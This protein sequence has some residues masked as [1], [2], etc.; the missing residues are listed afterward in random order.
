LLHAIAL[1]QQPAAS[2]EAWDRELIATAEVVHAARGAYVEALSEAF[3]DIVAAHRYHVA[4]VEMVYRPS[5]TEDLGAM[6]PRELRAGMSLVGP[7]RDVLEFV[8]DG[9][10]AAEVLSGGEGKMIV[11]FL[12][13]AKLEL[14]RR[15]HDE[16]PLFLLDDVDAELD[17]EILQNLLTKLPDFTQVFATSAKEAFLQA[18]RTGPHRRLTVV[19]GAVTAVRDFA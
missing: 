19:D 13:F 17:F 10:P 12:K 2:L 7:Q 5:T 15:R 1:R 18:L 9:R 3:R 16:P 14:Y 8:V 6:R 11:L 4:N